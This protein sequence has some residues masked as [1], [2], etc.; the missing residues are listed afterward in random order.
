MAYRLLVSALAC[1]LLA[2]SLYG[3]SPR[4]HAATPVLAVAPA[5][6]SVAVG[7]EFD[8]DVTVDDVDE[9]PGLGGYVV[10]MRYDPNVLEL[11]IMAD[12]GYVSGGENIVLCG[13]PEID[14]AQGL[15]A[16]FCQ[17]LPLFPAP[18]LATT[19]AVALV[20]T[21]FRA[22]AAGVSS[23]DLTDSYLES[24]QRVQI[25]ATLFA[26]SVEVTAPAQSTATPRPTA[27]TTPQPSATAAG[28]ATAAATAALSPVA[29]T[30]GGAPTAT[31]TNGGGAT[32]SRVEVPPAGTGSTGE[33][34]EW[35]VYVLPA[36]AALSVGGFLVWWRRRRA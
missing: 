36:A 20:T 32:L 27:T 7:Q 1:S 18:G 16:T 3:G 5:S 12:T 28:T 25:G 17:A 4:A 34:V 23:I 26:G 24:P 11:L 19:D 6:S 13:T 8:L 22:K 35:W 29:A 31:S 21:R 33:S 10:A 2:V 14:N 15:A 9:F 30:P